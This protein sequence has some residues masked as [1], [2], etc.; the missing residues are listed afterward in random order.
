MHN[1]KGIEDGQAEQSSVAQPFEKLLPAQ[2]VQCIIVELGTCSM[3]S[4]EFRR[5]RPQRVRFLT[6]LQLP[7]RQSTYIKLAVPPSSLCPH[8]A[9]VG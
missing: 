8:C 5:S 6:P 9:R 2:K 4:S 1:V 7:D 3:R